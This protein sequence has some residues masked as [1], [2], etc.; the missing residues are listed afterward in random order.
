MKSQNAILPSGDPRW[1]WPLPLEPY[2]RTADLKLCE[3]ETLERLFTCSD[4]VLLIRKNSQTDRALD[5]LLCPINDALAYLKVHETSLCR[6]RRLL[7]LEIQRRRKTFWAWTI[8]EWCEIITPTRAAFAQRYVGD[9][10]HDGRSQ[11]VALAYLLC[12]DLPVARLLAGI[13]CY[14][15]ARNVFGENVLRQEIERVKTILQSW[16][17]RQQYQLDLLSTLSYLFLFNRSPL[18]GDLST[19]V[20]EKAASTCPLRGN[21]QHAWYKLSRALAGLGLINKALPSSNTISCKVST[22]AG[23]DQAWLGWAKRWLQTSPLQLR[24]RRGRY[25]Q[26]LKVGRWLSATHPEITSPAQWSSELAAEFVAAV[27]QMKVGEW[28]SPGYEGFLADQHLGQPLVPTVRVGL[29]SAMQ[30]FLFDC[31]EWGWIPPTLNVARALK[32]PR[33]LR[34]LVG[35]NP[36]VVD[37]Q[38]WAKL[39]WAA[40][41]LEREDLPL[42][43]SNNE[44]PAYPL[45]LVRALAMVWCFSAL[46]GDEIRRLRMGCIRWQDPQVTTSPAGTSLPADA[47]C[48]LDVPVN[49]TSSA[50]TKPVHPLVGKRIGEWERV[51]P[52]DQPSTLDP[53]TGEAVKFLFC[54]RGKPISSDYINGA[55][56]PLLCRK[57][58]IPVEDSRGKITGHRA[59]ATM[60][61][62]LYNAREPLSIFELK[63]YLGHKNLNSTQHYLKIDPTKLASQVARAGY[64]EQN[65]ATIEVLLDQEA[66]RSGRASRGEV[67]KYYDLGHGYCTHDFWAECK[68]RMACARCP[69]YRPKNALK[70]QLVEGQANLVR[71]LEFVKLTEEEKQLV[72]E[73]IGLHQTLIEQL[74]NVPTPAGVTPRELATQE[75]K[76][77]LIPLESG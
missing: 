42:P 30:G 56:I 77:K 60:A 21:T 9:E 72:E 37:R 29:I 23:L 24:T 44:E 50:Y 70:D 51:R 39:I 16:G 61:S 74:Q 13:Q 58:G 66:V 41:N 40:M 52:S 62:M 25:Y 2:D 65:M 71:M 20:L 47:I 69:F 54:Y 4:K 73:G 3:Q 64:F 49:K 38:L 33:S 59:R 36:R 26:I 15:L 57:A 75:G 35:P 10:A 1:H 31:Q 27:Q 76:F 46:R 17:Y 14:A 55:L 6:A 67:W 22:E 12:P 48:L 45:E 34:I 43:G 5:R 8:E 18:L 28:I 11:L 32:A 53:K 7:L 68:H 19:E 63:E